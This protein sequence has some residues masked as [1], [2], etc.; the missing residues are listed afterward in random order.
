VRARDVFWNDGERRL[1]AGWRLALHLAALASMLLVLMLAAPV[2]P[3]W[4]AGP[5]AFA[6]VIAITWAFARFVDRRAFV[7]LGLRADRARMLD[8]A[9]GAVIGGGCIALVA[10]IESATG[11]AHYERVAIDGARLVAIAFVAVFFVGVAIQEELVFRGYH[12]VNLVEGLSSPRAGR[13]LGAVLATGLAAVGFGLAHAGNDGASILATL[14]VAVAGGT[15]LAIGFVLTGD[16]AFSIGLHFAWNFAQAI[17]GMPVSGFGLERAALM[18]REPVGSDWMT[19]GAFG[20]EA[21]VLG[22]AAMLVGT[23]LAL[24]WSRAR[25]GAIEVRLR[26]R[27]S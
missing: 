10:V 13:G 1:R 24:A 7:D 3:G 4:V 2:L 15:L 20:P 22:L 8:A 6:S 23:A 25:Y 11:A 5:I 16:L 14:Q 26:T 9:A 18:T 19:G 27:A 12:L 17:C 21:S